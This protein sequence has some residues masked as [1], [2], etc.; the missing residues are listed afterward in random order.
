M[1][2]P[3]PPSATHLHHLAVA[4]FTE[5]AAGS[6]AATVG[7]LLRYLSEILLG[8]DFGPEVH[9]HVDRLGL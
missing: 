3:L 5:V 4:E 2:A 1:H 6:G 7:M 8:R 9:E